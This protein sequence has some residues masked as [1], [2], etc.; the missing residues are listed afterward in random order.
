MNLNESIIKAIK[1][2]VFN[3]SATDEQLKRVVCQLEP[4]YSIDELIVNDN[5]VTDKANIIDY[6]VFDSY[7][8][9]E[10]A[11][12]DLEIDLLLVNGPEE[13][14]SFRNLDNSIDYWFSD[15][16]KDFVKMHYENDYDED[17]TFSEM[18]KILYDTKLDDV[19]EVL[20]ITRNWSDAHNDVPAYDI[21]R[22]AKYI[23]EL[24]GPQIVLA[25]YDGK[26]HELSV[27]GKKYF[28][29]RWN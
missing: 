5:R 28:A 10:D 19:E 24:D 22:L 27:D 26:E 16:F 29:Y 17:A 12:I 8:K 4:E 14:V 9:A 3:E 15:R 6:Y 1:C 11:A 25:G 23:I 7:D 20:R 18:F 2:C 13:M 21:E